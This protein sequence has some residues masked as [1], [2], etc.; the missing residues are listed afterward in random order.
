MLKVASAYR[1]SS[2]WT[3]SPLAQTIGGT[4]QHPVHEEPDPLEPTATRLKAAIA[5]RQRQAR[6]AAERASP[7]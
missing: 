3:P 4:A 6:T 2:G 5:Y 7:A 1:R